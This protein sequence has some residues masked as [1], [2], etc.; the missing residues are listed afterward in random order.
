MIFFSY[1]MRYPKY[2]PIARGLVELN[3]LCGTEGAAEPRTGRH[4]GASIA[5]MPRAVKWDPL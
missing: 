2:E 4:G 5:T 3:A 1:G